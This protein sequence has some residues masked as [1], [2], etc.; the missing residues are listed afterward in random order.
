MERVIDKRLSTSII[1]C[2]SVWMMISV[3]YNLSDKLPFSD[4]FWWIVEKINDRVFMIALLSIT[5][6]AF[7]DIRIRLF[8]MASIIY[9]VFRCYLELIYII[10]PYE[11]TDVMFSVAGIYCICVFIIMLVFVYVRSRR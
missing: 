8:A 9:V 7:T 5:A 2:T 11:N 3:V 10:N 6:L 1:I 4:T